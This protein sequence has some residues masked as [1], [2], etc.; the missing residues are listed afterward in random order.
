[1][2]RKISVFIVLAF[3]LAACNF[4]AGVDHDLKTGL[5][6]KNSGL[7]YGAHTLTYNGVAAK[8]D[9]WNRGETLKLEF[10]EVG[11][12]KEEQGLIYP[13]ISLVIT[14]MEGQVK[15]SMPDLLKEDTEHGIAPE[16]ATVLSASYTLGAVLEIGRE[17]QLHIRVYDK[18]GK[19]NIESKMKFKVAKQM[20]EDLNIHTSDLKYKE[21]Y[22]VGRNG[23]NKNEARL[24]GRIGLMIEGMN[25]FKEENGKVFPGA[26]ITIYDKQG[27]E[28]YHSEDIFKDNKAG[29]DPAKAQESLSL[30]LTLKDEKL[31]NDESKWVFKVWDKKG[32]GVL[33]ADIMLKL[34]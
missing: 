21:I 9:S 6:I 11:G 32:D 22:F 10:E 23:R 3:F 8:T 5:N 31:R 15:D 16:K 34:K 4:S 27:K 13:G 2:K 17:Y 7:R 30:F 19:G 26:D 33:E 14:D 24:G 18:K 20:Q 25:G 28:Q 1:M 29:D 12:F